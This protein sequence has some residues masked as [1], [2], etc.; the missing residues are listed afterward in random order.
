ML[1]RFELAPPRLSAR[2]QVRAPDDTG[3]TGS[4]IKSGT[5]LKVFGTKSWAIVCYECKSVVA[6]ARN[7]SDVKRTSARSLMDASRAGV[8]CVPG[9]VTRRE[10]C[11]RSSLH[12][13]HLIR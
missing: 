10:E 11:C 1:E 6:C 9:I 3:I 7:V 12:C 2:K 8:L 5:E 4:E 13:V